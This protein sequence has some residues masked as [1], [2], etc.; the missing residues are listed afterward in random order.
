M[1]E[2]S[3]R[4]KFMVHQSVDILGEILRL[5]YGTAEFAF[6]ESIRTKMTDVRSL[7][8]EAT[9]KV[10]LAE[11]KRLQTISSEQRLRIARSFTLMLQLMNTCENAYRS[12]RIQ[13][14]PATKTKDKPDSMVFV[15]TAHP[16][17]ARAPENIEIFHDILNHLIDVYDRPA[18]EFTKSDRLRLAH[19]LSLAL[20]A[21]IVRDRKPRVQDEAEL[22]YGT[23]LRDETLRTLLKASEELAPIYFRSWV[24]GDKD[25]HPGVDEKVFMDSLSLSRFYILKFCARRL[26]EVRESLDL[27]SA[28]N[29][30]QALANLEKKTTSLR[31]LKAGDAAAVTKFKKSLRD[32]SRSY[33]EEFNV[34]HPSLHEVKRLLFVFPGLVVPIEFRESSDVLMEPPKTGKLA[35]Q[36]MLDKLGAISKGGNPLW[37]VRGLIISMASE[38][39]HL[40]AAASMV[41]ASLGAVKIPVIPLFEQLEALIDGPKIIAQVLE[42]KK[43]KTAL[44]DYWGN[45]IEVMLGYSDSAKQ[46][47]VLR[48]RLQI[49]ETM[50]AIELLCARKNVLPVFFQGSGGSTDRG[51]GTIPEQTAWWSESAL[52]NYKVTVQG[53]MVER[54]LASPAITRG[55]VERIFEAVGPWREKGKMDLPKAKALDKFA[56]QVGMLYRSK[57]SD[58]DFLKVIESVTPYPYLN[59]LKFG[60]RPSKRTRQLSVGGLRAIP[61]ILC[62]TQT[63]VLFPT[64]WGVGQVWARTG[65]QD[66]IELRTLVKTHPLLASYVFALGATLAKVELPVWQAYINS[67]ELTDELKQKTWREFKSEFE[68]AHEFAKSILGREDLIVQRA[69]LRESILLRSPMIHPLNLLQIIA[70]QAGDAELLRVTVAGVSSGMMTTG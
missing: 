62:W 58:P 41:A 22:I 66:K 11:L 2:L 57:V 17:E 4:L 39:Q 59:M 43:L 51:G 18:V 23:L 30:I 61:W 16:T 54:S 65:E 15:M 1:A 45:R 67:S 55:Q 49:A 63:R 10:L 53:E 29:L 14:R 33:I 38:L 31:K 68:L 25:G 7:P 42:N 3:D 13:Q 36:K 35:I 27:T 46:V 28:K 12:H 44:K 21:P 24:G 40:E 69:W 19:S 32:F 26:K 5:E 56:E 70:M 20:R 60:S 37:Y 34:L 64:W 47:G 48:S 6:I 50:H 9:E 52:R 8:G